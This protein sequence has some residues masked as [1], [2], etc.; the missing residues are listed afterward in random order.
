VKKATDLWIPAQ[1]N[2]LPNCDWIHLFFTLLDSLWPLFE[3]NRL[4]L[5]DLCRLA[6]DN[7]LYA[8][9]KKGLD[10]G[11]F[12]PSIRTEGD[13]TGILMSTPPPP[14][15]ASMSMESGRKSASVKMPCAP[16]GCGISASC[17]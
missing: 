1:L 13:S 11:I 4:L 17:S 14:A 9:G 5:N 7:L 12:A 16:A 3:V 6:V 8:A 15:A 10:I 2:R